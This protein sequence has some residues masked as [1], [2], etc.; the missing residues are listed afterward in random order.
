MLHTIHSS[1]MF[2]IHQHIIDLPTP[3]HMTTHFVIQPTITPFGYIVPT[4]NHNSFEWSLLPV[5]VPAAQ[6]G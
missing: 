5:V 2:H 1:Y 4:H 6:W 3:F